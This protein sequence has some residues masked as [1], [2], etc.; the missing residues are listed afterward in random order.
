MANFDT[1]ALALAAVCPSN[2]MILDDKGMPGFYV[3]IGKQ[4]LSDLLNTDDDTVHPAFRIS[5]VE[6]PSL[7]IGKFQ[8]V[9]ENGRIYSLPGVDP[10]VSITHD[11][12]IERCRA[13]GSGHHCITAAEWGFLA[14]WCRKNG[15]MPKGNNNYGKDTSESVYQAVPAAYDS[16]G[17]TAR[18]LTGTGPLTWRH[19]GALDGIADLNGNVWEWT[20]GIRLVHGELQVIPWNNAADPDVDLGPTSAQWKAINAAAT[21]WED[22]FITPNGQGTTTGS[23]KL[24]YVSSHWQ[25]GTTITS[26]SDTSRSADFY[27]TTASGLSDIAKIYLQAL[28]LLPEDGQE[29]DTYGGVT[30][31]ANNAAEERVAYRGGG[32]NNGASRGVFAVYF[33]GPRSYSYG[34]ALGGRPAFVKLETE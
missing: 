21:S 27:L 26:S 6:Y 9:E 2:K 25:W 18:T 29:G 13:K 3:E 8:G 24:D 10:R 28:A 33:D 20:P 31:Y 4:N 15:T 32:W 1:S 30:F 12:Y 23:V 19:N 34:S 17:R 16:D 22:L 5:G 7:D 14:N 11:Q